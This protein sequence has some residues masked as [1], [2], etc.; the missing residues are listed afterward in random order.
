MKRIVF[1]FLYVFLVFL[2]A[3]SQNNPRKKIINIEP[4]LEINTKTGI[5]QLKLI[6]TLSN[7]KKRGTGFG[8]I[9]D[10]GWRKFNITISN[11]TINKG[12][13]KVNKSILSQTNHFCELR[14]SPK[15]NPA[16]SVIRTIEFPFV[17]KV[18]ISLRHDLKYVPGEK[19]ALKSYYHYSD[20]TMS[21]WAYLSEE[22]KQNLSVRIENNQFSPNM[23][24]MPAWNGVFRKSVHLKPI[25][26]LNDS[27]GEGIDVFYDTERVLY[28]QENGKQGLD[29]PKGNSAS[30][31]ASNGKDGLDGGDGGPG[32]SGEHAPSFD[33]FV[34]KDTVDSVVY[35][36]SKI[37]NLV[38][39]EEKEFY[40]LLEH[41]KLLMECKG[42]NG[43][44][45]GDGGS[46]SAGKD[47]ADGNSSGKGGT[48]G[49]GGLGGHGGDGGRVE[50]FLKKNDRSLMQ[51]IQVSNKGGIAGK[52]G[53]GG[54]KGRGGTAKSESFVRNLL[55]SGRGGSS[56]NDGISGQSG[57]DGGSPRVNYLDE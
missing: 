23:V 1:T 13:I 54:R 12:F 7:N 31:L 27:I 8:K 11:A 26:F 14:I 2:S 47:G 51:K 39:G 17:N 18:S 19:I 4:I 43:G 52:N 15:N 21:D 55:F 6:S 41:F 28:F 53:E 22:E 49:N 40:T 44:N 48:G 35:V 36:H 5:G 24:T 57:R 46:G 29:G 3:S 30:G 38:S 34:Q 25:Y 56:G 32:S 9:N 45:G 20:E 10:L 16:Y 42:G 37:K 33:I 50:V